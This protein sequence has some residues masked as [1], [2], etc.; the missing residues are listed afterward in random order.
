MPRRTP[1]STCR[2]ARATGSSTAACSRRRRP[3]VMRSRDDGACE[4]PAR[5][6]IGLRAPHVADVLISRP[7]IAWLEVHAENYMGGGPA[8]RTLERVRA[9]YRLS[10]HG[11]G[12]SLGSADGL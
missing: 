4:L 2:R 1:G 6:G 12:L 11:V 7:P 5:A 9:D 10:L 8:V 3:P